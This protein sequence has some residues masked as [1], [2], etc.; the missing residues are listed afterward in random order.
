MRKSF[1]LTFFILFGTAL[2]AQDNIGSGPGIGW[3]GYFQGGLVYRLPNNFGKEVN[4]VLNEFETYPQQGF[5]FGGGG[6]AVFNGKWLAG[7]EGF[8]L[9]YPSVAGNTTLVRVKGGGGAVHVG[10]RAFRKH[11]WM[12]F[13]TIGAGTFGYTVSIQNEG[14][15]VNQG[16]LFIPPGTTEVLDAGVMYV[17]I[18]FKFLKVLLPSQT[19]SPFT[20]LSVGYQQSLAARPWETS[21]GFDLDSF[22]LP[23]LSNFYVKLTLGIGKGY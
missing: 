16:N 8:L 4:L 12:A 13:P 18:S 2:F 14:F 17:D 19:G 5:A 20:G 9:F 7:G 11:N 23:E 15:L 3:I 6:M 22:S 21:A 1:I 10:Y